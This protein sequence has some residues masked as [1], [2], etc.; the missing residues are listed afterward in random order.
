MTYITLRDWACADRVTLA[1]VITDIVGSTT[2][3]RKLGNKAWSEAFSQHEK[4]VQDLISQFDCRK[5]KDIGD[6]FMVVFRTAM[7]ALDFALEFHANTGHNNIRI[8]ACIHVG[9]V[10]IKGNDIQG[11][12]VNFAARIGAWRTRIRPMLEAQDLIVLSDIAREHID[13][14]LGINS[15]R[16]R[17]LSS[18]AELKDFGTRK[19][20]IAITPE[21]R[22]RYE[23]ERKVQA[24]SSSALTRKVSAPQN[25]DASKELQ[26]LPTFTRPKPINELPANSEPPLLRRRPLLE[27][28]LKRVLDKK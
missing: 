10:R 19:L 27:E 21:M 1:L 25:T 23:A 15:P 2:L 14:E 7:D 18:E 12:M 16:V 11:G 13:E 6:G 22:C 28:A 8:R 17:F 20:W 4:G 5:F 24:R 9:A 3:N 26:R